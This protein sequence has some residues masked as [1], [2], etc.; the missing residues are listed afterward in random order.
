MR[1]STFA[2][3]LRLTVD[4]YP[5]SLLAAE[6]PPGTSG[7]EELAYGF[8]ILFDRRDH[9][10]VA[11]RGYL[12]EAATRGSVGGVASSHTYLGGTTRAL[13]FVPVGSRIVLAARIEGD[14][15]TADTP[16]FE[17]SRFGGVEPVEGVGGERSV[18]GLPKARYIGRA[19]ALAA[20]ELRVRMLNARL[21]ERVVSFGLA[22]FLDTGRVWQ[23][24]GNDGGLFDFHSGTG[25]GLRI[26]HGE[27][28]LRFDVGTSTE[29]AVNIYITFGNAF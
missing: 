24:Q 23:L 5:G 2:R 10:N 11:T 21:L 3:Y 29:R 20:A 8:G 28:L 12:L 22:A 16:L 25:G 7:G 6:R 9:E 17:L 18:R 15:L 14:I 27:F 13:G 26:Y 19:K 1:V 4:P